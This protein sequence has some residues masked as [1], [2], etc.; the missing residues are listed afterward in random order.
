VATV[1]IGRLPASDAWVGARKDRGGWELIVGTPDGTI[2]G[3]SRDQGDLLVAAAAYFDERLGDPPPDL[4]ATHQDIADLIGWLLSATPDPDR[5]GL[6][7]E[8]LDAVEDGLEGETVLARLMAAGVR[9]SPEVTEPVDVI[10]RLVALVRS[11][12]G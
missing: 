5:R 3:V 12:Q 11:A 1:A 7:R 2:R 9:S 4:E 6:L 10:D 8:V